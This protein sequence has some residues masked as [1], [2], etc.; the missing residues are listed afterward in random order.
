MSEPQIIENIQ[1]S[2]KNNYVIEDKNDETFDLAN[3]ITTTLNAVINSL[4]SVVP[5]LATVAGL[6]NE[7]IKIYEAAQYNKK[8]C[9]ALMD[10]VTSAEAAVKILQR[11][12]KEFEENF[13]K[14]EYQKAFIRL[15]N[16]L[17]K[18]KEFID[19]V[20]QLKG[21]NKYVIATNIEKRFKQLTEEY[22]ACMKDLSFTLIITFDEQRR[23]D[24]DSLNSD[25]SEMTK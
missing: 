15:I 17:E 20:T 13:R 25:L 24:R 12:K 23:I 2:S 3:G 7:I 21:L 5:W 16:S 4:T 1:V 18:I 14:I 11:R 9:A 10:R 19:D 6:I 22:E 8:I